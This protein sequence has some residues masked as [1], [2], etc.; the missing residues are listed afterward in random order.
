MV[1]VSNQMHKALGWRVGNGLKINFWNDLWLQDKALKTFTNTS[2]LNI[3]WNS[4]VSD[5]IKDNSSDI[6][7]LKCN[8]P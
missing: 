6:D 7:K 5:F 3:D 1:F 2:M 4:K 8:L